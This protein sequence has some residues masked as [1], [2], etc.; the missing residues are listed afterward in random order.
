[1]TGS[2]RERRTVAWMPIRR[3][4]G[5]DPGRRG[6]GNRLPGDGEPQCALVPVGKLDSA[7]YPADGSDRAGGQR[8]QLDLQRRLA[9]MGRNAQV[10]ESR[11]VGQVSKAYCAHDKGD[12][13]K[14]A[15]VWLSGLAHI[16]WTP[17]TPRS[18]GGRS[19]IG[20]LGPCAMPPG[21]PI[22]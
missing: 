10:L 17:T 7:A 12:A 18:F 2:E 11:R 4:Y 13:I 3:V 19:C 21:A 22:G 9:A 20:I 5:G 6:C 8:E 14:I 16:V 15:R 1:M